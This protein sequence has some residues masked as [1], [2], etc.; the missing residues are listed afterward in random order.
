LL[1]KYY[2]VATQNRN[3]DDEAETKEHRV[4]NYTDIRTVL[5]TFRALFCDLEE[6]ETEEKAQEYLDCNGSESNEGALEK[7][8][9]YAQGVISD[10]LNGQYHV[11]VDASTVEELLFKL[12]PYPYSLSGEEGQ[13]S[14]SPWPLVSVIDFG[15]EHPLLNEGITHGY[16]R[17]KSGT[18]HSEAVQGP[19]R[20]SK[21]ILRLRC[22]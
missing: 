2:H 21:A 14:S 19:H 20:R 16:A 1:T 8:A 9:A 22:R 15:L 10:H 4:E 3:D 18:N 17:W 5:D 12:Q 6:F 13:T 7:L 11:S